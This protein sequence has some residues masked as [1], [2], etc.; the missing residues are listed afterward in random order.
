MSLEEG[1]ARLEGDA[2]QLLVIVGAHPAE[3]QDALQKA[4]VDD[5]M[6]HR[7][8]GADHDERRSPVAVVARLAIA[9]EGDA[10]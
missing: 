4:H 5:D 9:L 7:G 6:R 3:G 2:R 8:G 1:R 10:C